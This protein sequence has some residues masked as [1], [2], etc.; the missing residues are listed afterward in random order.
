MGLIKKATG[1]LTLVSYYLFRSVLIL[2]YSSHCPTVAIIGN[3]LLGAMVA[4]A[5]KK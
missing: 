2:N 1:V 5:L 4:Q 3:D